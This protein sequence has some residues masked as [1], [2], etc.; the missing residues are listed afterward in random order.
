LEVF[1]ELVC[2]KIQEIFQKDTCLIGKSNSN[3][4]I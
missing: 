3:E 1:C 2:I 4:F